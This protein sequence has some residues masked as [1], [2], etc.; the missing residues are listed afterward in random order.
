M[1]SF[2][3]NND[4]AALED[5]SSAARSEMKQIIKEAERELSQIIEKLIV[6]EI[7]K[8]EKSTANALAKSMSGNAASTSG[9]SGNTPATT[10]GSSS[11]EQQNDIMSPVIN[12]AVER[13][14]YQMVRNGSIDSRSILKYTSRSLARRIGKNIGNSIVSGNPIFSGLS[15][16]GLFANTGLG[17]F[18]QLR[19]S[20]SQAAAEASGE[21]QF[22]QRNI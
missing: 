22:G 11:S 3:K 17:N 14:A 19:L 18:S 15:F 10:S 6:S 4:T 7:T 1:S 5:F 16:S 8:I 20:R 9:I 2:S 12:R 13:S 21:L